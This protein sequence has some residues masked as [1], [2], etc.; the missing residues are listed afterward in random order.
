MRAR[1]DYRNISLKMEASIHEALVAYAADKGQSLTTA[2]E[3]IL[4][5]KFIAEGFIKEED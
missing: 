5:E 3:R 1:K 2:I 4:K